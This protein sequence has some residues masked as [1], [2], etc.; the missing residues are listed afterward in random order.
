MAALI[1]TCITPAAV[2]R[3]RETYV[4]GD[5]KRITDMA[6]VPSNYNVSL[7]QRGQFPWLFLMACHFCDQLAGGE[8]DAD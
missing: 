3:N 5:M 2:P 1:R 8:S 4:I 7:L 6:V